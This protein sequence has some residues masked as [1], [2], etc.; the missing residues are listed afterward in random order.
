MLIGLD[1]WEE[2]EWDER[3][4]DSAE[5]IILRKLQRAMQS[6]ES[7]LSLDPDH[8]VILCRYWQGLADS[9]CNESWFKKKMN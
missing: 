4:P 5:P 3:N 9:V 1:S 6:T 2:L 8:P 7:K